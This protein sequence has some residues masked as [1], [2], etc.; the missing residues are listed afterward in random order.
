MRL[1]DKLIYH[2]LFVWIGSS[3][4]LFLVMLFGAG[5][6][7]KTM[8]LIVQGVPVFTVLMIA[9][10]AL[11]ALF[12]QTL[13]MAM[14]L[15]SLQ[16]FGRLSGDS[17]NIAIAASGISFYRVCQPVVVVGLSVSVIA[18]IWNDTVVPPAARAYWSTLQSATKHIQATDQPLHYIIENSHGVDEVVNIQGGYDARTQSLRN[19]TII[20]FSENP[21]TYGRVWMVLHAQ[22]AIARD[23]KGLNWDYINA[24]IVWL[25][26][27][28]RDVMYAQKLSTSTLPKGVRVGKT[29]RGVMQAEVTDN[30][31]KSF[32]ELRREIIAERS[33]GMDPL[34]DEVDL[35]QKL[36]LPLASLIFGVVGAPL[37]IRPQRGSRAV[38]FGIALLIIFLYW[39]IYHAA[40]Y[41]GK[42]GGIPPMAAAF[43]PDLLGVIAVSLLVA[44][45]SR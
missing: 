34:G 45:A 18:F 31:Q 30:N 38:G 42:S 21:K 32:G 9:I 43:L 23:P 12:T 5:Y 13:P 11:P 10:Y 22:R 27:Y 26:P 15:S 29:F 8:D 24:K 33:Q 44:R 17:E 25:L 35:Y 7:A 39:V 28:K 37:G 16:A 1:I 4:A 20:K 14:L 40:Y 36:S 19:V 6:L 3:I 41:V 2:E